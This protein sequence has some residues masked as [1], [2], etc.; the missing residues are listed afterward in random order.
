M[1]REAREK[2]RARLRESDRKNR[3]RRSSK[4]RRYY[5]SHREQVKE[6]NKRWARANRDKV[7]AAQRRWAAA[8]R[9]KFREWVREW[10]RRNPDRSRI[11]VGRL[12]GSG[13]SHSAREW[14]DLVHAHDGRC[15]YCGSDGRLERDHRI[16]ISRGGS[17]WI[18]NI[19]PACGLCNRRKGRLTEEE[20]RAR[21]TSEG[22]DR[23]LAA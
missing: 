12:H 10:Y 3:A 23:L 6:R 1:T 18:A 4:N 5:L 21:L 9:E 8:H 20:F 13:G 16:P 22:A 14:L 2:L 11:Y 19:L 7:R 17:D 15:A